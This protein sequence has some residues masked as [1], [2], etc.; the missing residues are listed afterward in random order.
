MRKLNHA[1]L[2]MPAKEIF[3]MSDPYKR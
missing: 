1:T 3:S 2:I